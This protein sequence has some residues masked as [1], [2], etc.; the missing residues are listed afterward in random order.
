MKILMWVFGGYKKIIPS[1]AQIILAVIILPILC[2]ILSWLI[3]D[4]NA[5]SMLTNIIDE[6]P[7]TDV[8]FDLLTTFINDSKFAL[9]LTEYSTIINYI[10]SKIFETCIVGMCVGLCKNIGIILRIRGVPIVQSILGVFLGCIT[11]SAFGITNDIGSIYACTFLIIANVIVIWL[12]PNGD[13]VRKGLATLLGLGLQMIIA[14]LSAGYIICLIS[15]MNGTITDLKTAV[16]CL[17]GM[18]IPFLLVLLFDYFFLTP[19]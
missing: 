11:V 17:S 14:A 9:G 18:F 6:F 16:I 7:V 15:I 5:S 10:N 3:G 13:F 12:I 8:W 19:D 1:I 4:N 2:F